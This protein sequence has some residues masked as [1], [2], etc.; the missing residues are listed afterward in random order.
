MRKAADFLS[1]FKC[2]QAR[3]HLQSN[4]LGNHTDP[5]IADQMTWK[6][7]ACKAP[8]TTLSNDEMQLP[9]KGIDSDVFLQEMRVLKADMAPGL[10]CPHNE[11]L[12]T[13]AVNQ[14]HQMMPRAAAAID[15][16]LN[17]ANAVV[18]VQMPDYFYAVW[19]FSRLVPS[20]KVPDDSP[21]GTTLDCHPMNIGS[22]KRR[23][24]T[25]AFFNEDLKATFN[26]IVGPV[27]NGVGKQAGISITAFGVAVELDAALEFGVIQ[28]D[29]KN[30]YNEVSHKSIMRAL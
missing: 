2:S 21:T 6:Y 13:L 15:N 11:H 12:L 23:L 5:A 27:Q 28:G 3:K 8:I 19:I 26:K 24:I 9:R 18:W 14:F 10:G 30:G 1:H 7:P 20:N 16:Y 4:G 22:A 29:H 25:R 17:N